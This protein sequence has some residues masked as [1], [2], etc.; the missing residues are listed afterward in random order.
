MINIFDVVVQMLVQLVNLIPGIL[1]LYLLFDLI[2]V[3]LFSKR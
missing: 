1:G 2:G 3:L